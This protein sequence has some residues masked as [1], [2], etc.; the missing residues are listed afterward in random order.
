VW[1]G[2]GREVEEKVRITQEVIF[3][4]VVYSLVPRPCQR[5]GLGTKLGGVRRKEVRLE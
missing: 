2:S 1:L 4:K 3:N 5:E